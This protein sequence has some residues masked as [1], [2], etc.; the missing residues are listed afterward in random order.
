MLSK[1][2]K[3]NLMYNQK[4]LDDPNKFS[5]LFDQEDPLPNDSY[6][7][8]A[9]QNDF[10]TLVKS[11]FPPKKHYINFCVASLIMNDNLYRVWKFIR[12][13]TYLSSIAP[14]I[15]GPLK[16]LH[17]TNTWSLSNIFEFFYINS[18]TVKAKCIKIKSTYSPKKVQITW[19]CTSI[20]VHHI[21][22]STLYAE[23]NSNRTLVKITLDLLEVKDIETPK[24][25]GGYFK[26]ALQHILMSYNKFIPESVDH[27]TEYQSFIVQ[28][29]LDKVWKFVINFKNLKGMSSFIGDNFEN[30]GDPDKK[31]SFWK[32]ISNMDHKINF[33]R[34]SEVMNGKNKNNK[35]SKRNFK[36]YAV[37]T[38]GSQNTFIKQEM[39][40]KITQVYGNKCQVALTHVFKEKITKKFLFYFS[41]VKHEFM[42]KLK[43][44]LEEI[45]N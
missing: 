34:V 36:I 8:P 23:S 2:F 26:N 22:T 18:F 7:Y 13:V 37:E 17:G 29:D 15:S 39:R 9:S 5:F 11:D 43:E 25:E 41:K 3:K 40:M 35:K 21:K 42:E 10:P 31:G 4:I 27:L 20:G 19:D 6:Q 28:K 44:K 12:D 14:S 24:I 33:L 30:K 1:K 32:C 16:M 38:F 45:K